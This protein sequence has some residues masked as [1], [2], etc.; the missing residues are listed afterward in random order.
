MATAISATLAPVTYVP[1]AQASQV[2]L[3]YQQGV[4]PAEIAAILDLSAAAVDG[5]LGIT[6]AGV[7]LLPTLAAK[8]TSG[9]SAF[10]SISTVG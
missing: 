10:P 1:A 6:P 9:G 5:Y 2:T 7:V 4:S 8:P 3:L